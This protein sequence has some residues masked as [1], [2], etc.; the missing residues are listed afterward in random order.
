MANLKIS[1]V[2]GVRR[3][4]PGGGIR[5]RRGRSGGRHGEGCVLVRDPFLERPVEN[6]D[7]AVPGQGER[8]GA[9]GGGDPGAAVGDDPTAG[10]GRGGDA[11][12]PFV[13]AE[14]RV[15]R[16]VDETPG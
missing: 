7:V 13:A 1:W 9:R 6:G 10:G 16:A 4:L 2:S 3:R 12:P 11:L 8:E 15:R 5:A 14:E